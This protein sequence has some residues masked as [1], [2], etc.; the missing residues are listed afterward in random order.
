MKI[1]EKKIILYGSSEM[2]ADFKYLFPEV[3]VIGE[4]PCGKIG[5]KED[6]GQEVFRVVCGNRPDGA[7]EA[8]A[9]EQGLR[10]KENYLYMKD[11]F[12]YYNPMFLERGNRKLAVWGTGGAAREL[13]EKLEQKGL[14]SEIDF[15]IDNDPKKTSF[16]G[17]KVVSPK[18]IRGREDLYILVAA[19]QCQWEIYR[20]LE[21]YG[22]RPQRD[23]IH[24]AAVLRDY[25]E[26][27]EKVCFAERKYS[28]VC[29]RPF[30]YCDVIYGELYVCCPD[31]LPVSLGSMRFEPFMSC[32]NSYAA[33]IVRLSVLN[34]TFAFCSRQ[35]CDLFEFEKE[36]EKPFRPELPYERLCPE[37]PATLMAGIDYSCNLKCPSC[38]KEVCT[39]RREEREEMNRQAE[40]L[41]EHVIPYVG[42]LWMA[43]SGEVFFSRVYR[44]MLGD[45]RCR[46]RESISILSNGT[47]FDEKRW[48]WIKEAYAC[49]EV[50]ISMDG[51]R[52]A[53]IEKLRR[54]ADARKLKANLEFLGNLR[55][56]NQ[57]RKLFLSCVLQAEN[58]AELYELLEYCR[59][60]G[61][62]KVQ[63]LKLKDNGI[64][65][66][67]ENFSKMSLF[68]R[69][70]CLKEEYRSYFTEE[71]LGHP[72]A[73][74][75]NST[76][77]LGVEKKPRLD[78]YD[79]F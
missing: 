15:Y 51:I 55:K 47:L 10:Y 3:S 13:W 79:T 4:E 66:D 28:C 5:R 22:F 17:K 26:L 56:N 72:L 61:V 42:R 52:D 78:P 57:I 6:Q 7:F 8:F 32:W 12:R 68:D 20:Q 34:G 43:G 39:A 54:G 73:D 38:R 41:L 50:V 64:Y 33:R 65:T 46:K 16:Q 19:W 63:F 14:S 58:V 37:Y 21:T 49:V 27:L 59:A 75:F 44:E 74:W 9:G 76:R 29:H 67:N 71:V 40:D 25:E 2:R 69:E 24:C 18:E 60:V 31:F 53:T 48:N 62:D 77:A 45:R 36:G 1:W 70:D 30:G 11:F 23:F 35:Y